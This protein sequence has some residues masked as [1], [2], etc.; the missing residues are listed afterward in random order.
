MCIPSPTPANL[1]LVRTC[2]M[3]G[4]SVW[5]RTQIYG[6]ISQIMDIEDISYYSFTVRHMTC[7]NS[8]LWAWCEENVCIRVFGLGCEGAGLQYLCLLDNNIFKY[9]NHFLTDK[10]DLAQ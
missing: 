5:L 1:L 3:M 4:S 6:I 9:S 2:E 8:H 7:V 10:S